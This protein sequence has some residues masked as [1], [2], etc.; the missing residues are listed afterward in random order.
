M[1]MDI[2]DYKTTLKEVEKCLKPGGIL[3][4][5]ESDLDLLAEDQKSFLP[6]ATEDD[7]NGS[8]LRRV[9]YGEND[10]P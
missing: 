3:I 4:V 9:M 6:I 5:M 8:W 1:I 10:L 2:P 7:T